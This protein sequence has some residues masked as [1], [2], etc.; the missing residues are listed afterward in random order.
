MH[1]LPIMKKKL[2]ITMFDV[3]FP[4]DFSWVRKTLGPDVEISGGPR[5]DLLLK[6]SPQMV[7]QETKRILESGIMDGGRFIL[8]EGNN[9]APYTPLENINAMYSTCL[10][11][12]KYNP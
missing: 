9:L 10:K 7:E 5:I 8:R 1:H 12:G 2:K 4:I 3:G 6:E 11:Y